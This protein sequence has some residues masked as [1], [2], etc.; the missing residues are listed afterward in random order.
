MI[1]LPQVDHRAPVSH[2]QIAKFC[3]A[4][5]AASFGP[6][7]GQ[8]GFCSRSCRL[9]DCCYAAKSERRRP[10]VR[11]SLARLRSLS[12]IEIA[13]RTRYEMPRRFSWFRWCVA[14]SIPERSDFGS[15]AEWSEFRAEVR[16]TTAAAVDSG[17]DVH[18]PV[19]TAQKARTWRGVLRGLGV[20][21]RRSAQ[22]QTVR[23]LLRSRDHRSWVVVAPGRTIHAGGVRRSVVAENRA[24]AFRVAEQVRAAGQTCVVCPYPSRKCGECRACASPAVDVVLYPFHG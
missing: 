20:V 11:R 19:E 8:G 5:H 2:G 15:G 21:V 23:A 1:A 7:A 12:P 10:N 24:Y 3:A 6:S 17:A 22:V 14:G 4:S 16:E 9:W 13:R 18:F